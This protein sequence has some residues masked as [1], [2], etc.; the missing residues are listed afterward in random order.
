VIKTLPLDHTVGS[1]QSAF[2]RLDEGQYLPQSKGPNT[3]CCAAIP[4]DMNS[5]RSFDDCC[6]FAV[7]RSFR[8]ILA[9]TIGETSPVT[10]S[11]VRSEKGFFMVPGRLLDRCTPIIYLLTCDPC[12]TPIRTIGRQ[13]CHEVCCNTSFQT[14]QL[15]CLDSPRS[16]Q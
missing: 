5:S 16:D 13:A 10:R 4:N 6:T 2:Q 14:C 1:L 15:P 11:R 3:S 8:N 7:S 9:L 12:G